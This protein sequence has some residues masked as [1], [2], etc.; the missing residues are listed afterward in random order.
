MLYGIEKN[1][2]AKEIVMGGGKLDYSIITPTCLGGELYSLI[3]ERFGSPFINCQIRRHDFV[4]I[5]CNLQIYLEAPFEIRDNYGF[6]TL[7]L[8]PDSLPEAEIHFPHD[9]DSELVR[10]N[11][12]KR[13][14]RVNYNR[15][16]IILDDRG[17][18]KE[19]IERFSKIKCLKKVFLTSKK[20]DFDF[21]QII[22]SYRGDKSVGAYYEKDFIRGLW[23]FEYQWDYMK[24]L[25]DK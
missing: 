22:E 25:Y 21:C 10:I 12:I 16:V 7:T 11:W 3:G 9:S 17:T 4:N 19:D 8:T 13:R 1:I 18:I 5:I 14:V 24:F 20:L 6:I 2:E 23:R 15:L